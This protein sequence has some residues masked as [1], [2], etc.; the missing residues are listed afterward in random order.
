M[1]D[2]TKN[3]YQKFME[4][5]LPR[6]STVKDIPEGRG[7][8][9]Q[10]DK[11]SSKIAQIR[12]EDDELTKIIKDVISIYGADKLQS[13]KPVLNLQ[14]ELYKLQINGLRVLIKKYV[15]DYDDLQG[16]IDELLLRT[17]QKIKTMNEIMVMSAE[18]KDTGGVRDPKVLDHLNNFLNVLGNDKLENQMVTMSQS[19]GINNNMQGGSI[20]QDEDY[21]M[22]DYIGHKFSEPVTNDQLIELGIIKETNNVQVGGK[23]YTPKQRE[24]LQYERFINIVDQ[25]FSIL[26]SEIM[27][28]VMFLSNYKNKWNK[29][30][31]KLEDPDLI[32]LINKIYKNMFVNITALMVPDKNFSITPTKE[33]PSKMYKYLNELYNGNFSN[34]VEYYHLAYYY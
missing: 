19:K 11:I 23:E 21:K 32:V 15:D 26:K 24:A 9:S 6:L 25:M 16:K 10:V 5:I 14:F 29:G 18:T 20:Q 3:I 28:K 1:F 22:Y 4:T 34:L 2:D 13:R 27:V 33:T 8:V 17:Q 7:K 30:L 31:V 12:K